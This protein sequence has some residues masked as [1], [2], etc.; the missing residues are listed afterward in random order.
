MFVPNEQLFSARRVDSCSDDRNFSGWKNG[1]LSKI[2]SIIQTIRTKTEWN[3]WII[4]SIESI[5]RTCSRTRKRNSK[6]HIQCAKTRNGFFSSSHSPRQ[7]PFS[8]SGSKRIRQRKR[9]FKNRKHSSKVNQDFFLLSTY[10]SI[11]SS[12][13]IEDL[14]QIITQ[15]NDQ[16]RHQQ[17]STETSSIDQ[18]KFDEVKQLKSPSIVSLF[19]YFS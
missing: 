8:L 7:S 19:E 2:D 10:P 1:Y 18:Q 3:G 17:S 5:T 6:F 16:L 4:R 15:L 11:L 14:K 9:S 12:Q 13:S